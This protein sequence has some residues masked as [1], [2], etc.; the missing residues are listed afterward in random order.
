M[1]PWVRGLAP[2]KSPPL[3]QW[4]KVLALLRLTNPSSFPG[5]HTKVGEH[6]NTF[7]KGASKMA[8][9]VKALANKPEGL[10][11]SLVVLWP[12]CVPLGMC[13]S[14]TNESPHSVN[15]E[16]PEGKC[17]GTAHDRQFR[18]GHL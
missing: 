17:A 13:P 10:S 4:V 2:I 1:A 5:T 8:Q 12:P 18:Y 16:R 6:S 9:Q 15:A 11:L 3:A 7:S 14:P